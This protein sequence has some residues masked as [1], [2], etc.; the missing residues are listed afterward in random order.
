MKQQSVIS[1]NIVVP[2]HK[3]HVKRDYI[4]R[5]IIKYEKKNYSNNIG[6]I[7]KIIEILNIENFTIVQGDFSGNVVYRVNFMVEHCN[8]EVG[9]TIDCKIL[10]SS[11]KITLATN[12]P[13]KIIIVNEPGLPKL[14]VDNQ[15][16]IEI[17]CKEINY[18]SENIKIV[19]RFQS[20][21]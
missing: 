21:K 13:L 15:V 5:E 11:A 4:E 17:L 18:G 12:D 3:L 9:S 6:Y 10:H 2:P 8:P 7:Y 19:G 1:T 16:T 14:E 20:K